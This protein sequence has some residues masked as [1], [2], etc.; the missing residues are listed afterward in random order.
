MA[1]SQPPI[2]RTLYFGTFI[3][4]PT[5]KDLEI[6]HGALWVSGSG[7]IEGMDWDVNSPE[8]WV[9]KMG[10]KDEETKIVRSARMGFFFP[11]FIGMLQFITRN[12]C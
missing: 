4:T 1:E 6:R 3:N 5:P 11:G 2:A 8:E 10:W 7:E 9:Q 12:I